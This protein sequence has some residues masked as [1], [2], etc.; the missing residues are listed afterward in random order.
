MLDAT[1]IALPRSS[2]M[3][4]FTLKSNTMSLTTRSMR[5]FELRMVTGA[6]SAQFL[7]HCASAKRFKSAILTCE[8]DQSNA[9]HKYLTITLS[10]VVISSFEI[11]GTNEGNLPLERVTLKFTKMEFALTPVAGGNFTCTWDLSLNSA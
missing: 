2:L 9:R 1:R 8:Q 10:N 6:A 7:L 5:D 4:G 3:R 11:E